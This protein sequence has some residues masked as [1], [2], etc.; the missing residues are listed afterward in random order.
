MVEQWFTP[1]GVPSAVTCDMGPE[2]VS[3]QF[4]ELMDR[5]NVQLSHVAVEAPWQNGLA[6][7]AGG[8]LKTILRTCMAEHSASEHQDVQSCVVAALEAM[9]GGP[10]ETGFSPAQLVL[11]KQPRGFGQVIPN[12]LQARLSQHGLIENDPSFTQIAAMKETAR[13][14]WHWSD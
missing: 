1:L 5:H 8:T 7:R 3:D 10:S 9:N 13:L 6:E 2:F 4:Q 14:V 12:D 11:G